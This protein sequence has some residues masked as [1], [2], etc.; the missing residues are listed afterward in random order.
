MVTLD[1]RLI[2]SSFNAQVPAGVR[3]AKRN[4]LT[5]GSR[6][7]FERQHIHAQ[8]H[9]ARVAKLRQEL[10]DQA[11]VKQRKRGYAGS[12]IDFEDIF[13]YAS[14]VRQVIPETR[15][16]PEFIWEEGYWEEIRKKANDAYVIP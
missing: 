8:Q 4:G 10:H 11:F 1:P 7:P 16:V 6:R 13:R 12:K 14:E 9:K 15:T 3:T 5:A 2:S